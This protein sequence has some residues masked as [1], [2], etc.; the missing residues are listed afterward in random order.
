MKSNPLWPLMVCEL[1]Q[2]FVCL[3]SLLINGLALEDSV[4]ARR[5]ILH[6]KLNHGADVWSRAS[7]RNKGCFVVVQIFSTSMSIDRVMLLASGYEPHMIGHWH[8]FGV[9]RTLMSVLVAFTAY[10][11]MVA[12]R[13]LEREQLEAMK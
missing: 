12:F 2:A 10:V 13:K 8:V 5:D 3:A 4:R 7:V 11:T 1:I 6:S 9:L